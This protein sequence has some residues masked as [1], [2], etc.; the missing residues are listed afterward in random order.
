MKTKTQ[1]VCNQCGYVS[2]K[3]LGRCPDCEAW[4]SFTEEVVAP[5]QPA[6]IALS[7]S[8]KPIAISQVEIVGEKRRTTGIS[9]LDTVLG[10]GIVEGSLILVGGDPGIGKSTLLL[11]VAAN[12][13]Q[14]GA[15]VLYVSGEESTTQIRLRADR[16]KITTDNL[17][18]LSETVFE[19]IHQ[20]VK[21]ESP[22]IL[23]VDS[24]QT[25]TQGDLS[26]APGSVSQVREVTAGLMR[27]AKSRSMATFI[28]GHVTKSGS[29]AGPKVLEHIVDTVLYFEGDGST[30]HR[31]VRSVKN[32]F[33]STN[34]IALFSMT[35]LGLKEITNP[36]ELFVSHLERREPG[37]AIFASIEGTRPLLVELQSLVSR[38]NFG[39]PRRMSLGIDYNKLVMSI[40]I[41]EKKRGLELYDQDIYVNAVGGIQLAE[42]ALTLPM[43]MSIVS[44][45]LSKPI[46]AKTVIIGE[47]GLLGEIRPVPQLEK[48]LQEAVKLGYKRAIV[49]QQMNTKIK[50]L[51]VHPV[52]NLDQAIEI[53]FG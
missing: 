44:S 50:G 33:G 46:P 14:Q 17:Y 49:P 52:E 8:K 39:N 25:M 11:Q 13:A 47:V 42:P 9:E 6:G 18:L 29:I 15:K 3:W 23:I 45:F 26:S 1:F 36:S 41:L 24:I 37:T 7:D 5:K 38:T 21:T 27:L 10:G 20:T 4:N 31:I 35:S 16:L 19:Q 30:M 28:V 2:A 34:E 32:R 22:D 53:T 40:A 43:M 48:R 51:S 12:I